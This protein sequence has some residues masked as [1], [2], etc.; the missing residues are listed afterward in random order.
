MLAMIGSAIDGTEPHTLIIGLVIFCVPALMFMI[1][2]IIDKRAVMFA[3]HAVFLAFWAF[4]VISN[5]ED[6]GKSFSAVAADQVYMLSVLMA[7]VISFAVWFVVIRAFFRR[8][9]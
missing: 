8:K 5:A 4:V 3:V 9:N 2:G 7:V 1:Y 6:F